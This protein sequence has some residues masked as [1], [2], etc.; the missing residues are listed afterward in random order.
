MELIQTLKLDGIVTIEKDAYNFRKSRF[1]KFRENYTNF[2]VANEKGEHFVL[3]FD[4]KPQCC[5]RFDL[6]Y[7]IPKDKIISTDGVIINLYRDEEF[8]CLEVGYKFVLEIKGNK[9]TVNFTFSNEHN[10]Y[11]SHF[12]SIESGENNTSQFSWRKFI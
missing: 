8:E 7:N 10:G 1:D 9:A 3:C 12:V 5:E 2:L 6:T 4:E 11:Y